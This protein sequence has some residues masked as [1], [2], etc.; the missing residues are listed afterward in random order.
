MNNHKGYYSIKRRCD[1]KDDHV[2]EFNEKICRI[3]GFED[4]I[5]K[6]VF[7]SANFGTRDIVA[8]IPANLSRAI[9]DQMTSTRIYASHILSAILRRL[10]YV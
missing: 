7:V 4:P 5:R 1:C 8:E 10:S 9:P 3:L 6:G 2:L